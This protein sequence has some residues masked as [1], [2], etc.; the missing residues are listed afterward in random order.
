VHAGIYFGLVGA[1]IGSFFSEDSPAGGA[2]P[3]GLAAGLGAGLAAPRLF[4]RLSWHDGQVR[5]MGAASVWGGVIGG[6]FADS[7]KTSGTNGRQVLVGASLGATAGAAGGV[8]LARKNNYTT[9]DI[10]LVDTFAGM[11]AV[12]GLTIGM[13][14][15]PAETEAYSVNSIIGTASGVV[16]GLIAAPKTNT[17]PRRM[18]R[19]AGASAIGG[20]VPFLLYAGLYDKSSQADERLTGFLSSAGLI[21][22]AWLGFRMTRD[23][24]RDLDVLPGGKKREVE[25]APPA[26]VSRHSD[27]RWGHGALTLQ[28]LSQTL[29]P[30]RGMTVPLLGGAF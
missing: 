5:T 28:P 19:V 7:V 21:A 30:Q 17:T 16:V 3:L 8:L 18:L 4:N 6:F 20:A 9:G 24:D 26:L 11:G 25:D 15:Q 1:T 27:G 14:M 22:G 23:M 2:V 13:L 10:A 12:G 29:A